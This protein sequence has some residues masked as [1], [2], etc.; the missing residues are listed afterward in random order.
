MKKSSSL[1][2]SLALF[3]ASSLL[4]QERHEAPE[5]SPEIHS[6]RGHLP[7]PPAPRAD[8]N[9][10]PEGEKLQRGRV[11]KN[12]HVNNNTWYGHAAPNDQRFHLEHP[13][14]HGRFE[15]I[16]PSF[17][18]S[19][20]RINVHAHRFWFPGGFFFEIAPWDWGICANWCWTCANDLVIYDDP[21]HP[22]WYLLYDIQTGAYVHVQYLG[23]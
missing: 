6:N 5:R 12:Q 10:K 1:A 15:H 18:Y 9:V 8:R 16:G 19:V 4:A 22:G 17:H 11:N 23:A 14:E 20:V 7:P 13:F 3:L 21:D 2:L